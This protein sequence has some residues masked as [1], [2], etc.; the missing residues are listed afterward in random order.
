MAKNKLF[1]TDF[2]FHAVKYKDL[3]LYAKTLQA[4]SV[5]KDLGINI[6]PYEKQTRLTNI[7]YQAFGSYLV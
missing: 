3:G 4:W 2:A 1:L 5:I 7:K 6:L